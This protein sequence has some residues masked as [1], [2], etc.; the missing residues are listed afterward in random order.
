[1]CYKLF[2]DSSGLVSWTTIYTSQGNSRFLSK[3]M[4][5]SECPSPSLSEHARPPDNQTNLN[6]TDEIGTADDLDDSGDDIVAREHNTKA[7]QQAVVK[8]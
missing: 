3:M 4:T 6:T 7:I 2:V 8:S 1:M 5:E